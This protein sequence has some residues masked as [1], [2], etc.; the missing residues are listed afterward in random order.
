MVDWSEAAPRKR[1]RRFLAVAG[2]GVVV[3]L[4][5]TDA[6]SIVTAAQSGAGWGYRLLWLQLALIPVLYI[7][8]ELTVRLGVVTG[9]GQTQLIGRHFGRFWAWVSVLTLLVCCMGALMTELAGLAGVGALLNLPPSL[10]MIL[11]VG[12]LLLM[13]YTHS[14]L[15]VERIAIALG[16]FELVFLVVA[17]LVRPDPQVMLAQAVDIPWGDR[18][19]L[20]LVAANIGAVIMPWM[21]FFQQSAIVEKKITIADLPAARADTMLGAVLTQVIMASVLVA[22]A[23]TLGASGHDGEL[24]TVQRIAEAI[25]PYLGNFGGKLL[26]GLGMAGAALVAAIVVTITAARTLSELL[27]LKCS[28]DHDP[29]EAPWFY[30]AYSVALIGC[31]LVV[32]SGVNLVSLSVGVQVMNSLL[33]PPVLGFLFLLARRLPQPYRLQGLYAA[34]CSGVIVVAAG[35]GVYSGIAGLFE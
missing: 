12:A 1:L 29:R 24:D 16:A 33:L 31:A 21:V 7:V 11:V 35:F 13:A 5:D 34:I 2:P 6:G 19:Y 10:T 15:T 20:Y 22:A 3:M 28:L 30:G 8:Q 26:F 4:A 17:V 27:G 18:K 25:T 14:Y 32:A 9:Q 23:A